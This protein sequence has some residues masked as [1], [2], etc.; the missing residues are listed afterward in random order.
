LHPIKRK[1]NELERGLI[2]KKSICLNGKE[3]FNYIISKF[4][5]MMA[6]AELIRVTINE[7][8]PLSWGKTGEPGNCFEIKKA[9][10]KLIEAYKELFDWEV[11]LTFTNPPDAFNKLKNA[12]LG[13]T[14]EVV[15]ELDRI[16]NEMEKIFQKENPEGH[17]KIELIFRSPSNIE[18]FNEELKRLRD[19]PEEWIK[20]FI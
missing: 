3:F 8:I 16:H 9:T 20:E 12:L 17:Y 1:F 6:L 18:V 14:K 7:E 5:D 11:D 13:C 4:D 19:H 15:S 2:F 10:D